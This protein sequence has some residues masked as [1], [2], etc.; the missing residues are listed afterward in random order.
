MEL[1]INKME[2]V[3]AQELVLMDGVALFLGFLQSIDPTTRLLCQYDGVEIP[4]TTLSDPTI[5]WPGND[6]TAFSVR[7]RDETLDNA[8]MELN[9]RQERQALAQRHASGASRFL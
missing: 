4:P 6:T 5:A 7:S 8:S 2:N 9:S 3:D 1:T